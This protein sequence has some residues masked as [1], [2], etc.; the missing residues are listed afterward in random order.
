MIRQIR[1]QFIAIHLL[2]SPRIQDRTSYPHHA[3]GLIENFGRQNRPRISGIRG[4]IQT[5]VIEKDVYD[6]QVPQYFRK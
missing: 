3:V 4:L 5:Q 1:V 6:V 2:S